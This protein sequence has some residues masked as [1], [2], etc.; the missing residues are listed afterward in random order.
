MVHQNQVL[1]KTQIYESVWG[2]DG[3][4]SENSVEVYVHSL[5]N[6]LESTG[7]QRVLHTKRG[8]GYI[9]KKE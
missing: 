4:G 6:K 1:S 7:Y 3:E 8:I 9:M 2:W 5:R